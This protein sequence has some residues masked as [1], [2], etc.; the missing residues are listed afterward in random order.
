MIEIE[1]LMGPMKSTYTDMDDA[2][3]NLMAI[4]LGDANMIV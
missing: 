3:G 4:V 1:C 2:I